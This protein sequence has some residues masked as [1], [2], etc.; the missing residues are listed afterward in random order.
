MKIVK[1]AKDVNIVSIPSDRGIRSGLNREIKLQQQLIVSIPSDRGI[2]SGCT[3]EAMYHECSVESQ[4]PLIGAF[5]PGDTR[6]AFWTV[7][8]VSQSPLIGAFVPGISF[9]RL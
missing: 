9:F 2:R 4:S 8:S 3:H 7:K 6:D 5:V 1:L